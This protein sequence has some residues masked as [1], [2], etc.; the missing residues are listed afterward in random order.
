MFKFA[1]GARE[2]SRLAVVASAVAVLAGCVEKTDQ[3]ASLKPVLP[4]IDRVEIRHH[5]EHRNSALQLLAW[6]AVQAGWKDLR[7]SHGFAFES[8]TGTVISTHLVADSAGPPLTALV[9]RAGDK[10]ARITQAAGASH[11]ERVIDAP[12]YQVTSL[13]PVDPTSPESLVALQIARGGKNSLFEKILPRF[14]QMLDADSR[15]PV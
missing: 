13:S 3:V 7:A 15:R 14:R 2:L 8:Q 10:S 12:G 6:L 1:V 9:L 5:P 11:V 4:K